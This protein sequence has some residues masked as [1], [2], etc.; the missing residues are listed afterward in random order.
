LLRD[1]GHDVR[2]ATDVVAMGS[3]DHVIAQAADALGAVVVT[4]DPHFDSLI[5]RASEGRLRYRDASRLSLR[6]S[7]TQA[8]RRIAQLITLLEAEYYECQGLTD[9][10]F[11]VELGLSYL[12]IVR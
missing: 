12:R 6:C 10:R 7:E 8:R 2:L 1:R 4:F 9:K 3:A 5:P 11:I